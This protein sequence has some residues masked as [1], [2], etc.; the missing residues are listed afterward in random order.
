MGT[1]AEE[2]P[3]S[4][5]FTWRLRCSSGAAARPATPAAVRPRY[6]V[7]GVQ[8][9]IRTEHGGRLV[10]GDGLHLAR[11]FSERTS[12]V[13]TMWRAG[14]KYNA[15][16]RIITG[17]PH[18]GALADGAPAHVEVFGPIR[19]ARVKEHVVAS[20]R[21][22][23][24]GACQGSLDVADRRQCVRVT[25]LR[26][27]QPSHRPLEVHVLPRQRLRCAA[28]GSQAHTEEK[29]GRRARDGL[30]GLVEA[31]L[32]LR[33]EMRRGPLDSCSFRTWPAFIFGL[34][35]CGSEKAPHPPKRDR[36]RGI[37]AIPT[38]YKS[39]SIASSSTSAA[40]C[41]ASMSRSRADSPRAQES[42]ASAQACSM[43]ARSDR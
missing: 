31:S 3:D 35:G 34:P 9:R 23:L 14:C 28:A 12:L 24:A 19:V 13:A 8:V 5:T 2:R 4:G 41:F 17:L 38:A 36:G 42:I 27:V 29:A 15:V 32:L 22:H 10:T 26:L 43:I 20:E 18:A 1:V 39:T 37:R 7:V 25:V 11:C 33:R 30:A 6:R 40:R 16:Q 21:P